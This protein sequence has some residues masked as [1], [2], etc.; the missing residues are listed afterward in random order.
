[1]TSP[2]AK[3]DSK[4]RRRYLQVSLRTLFILM[5]I[6]A[7]WFGWAMHRAR[8]QKKAVEWVR[9]MG[10]TVQYDYEVDEYGYPRVQSDCRA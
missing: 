7:V 3:P 9:E 5:T 2:S 10:G 8:E 1:M 4:P 6:F